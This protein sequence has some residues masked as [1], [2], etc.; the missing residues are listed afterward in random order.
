MP[1]GWEVLSRLSR[2]TSLEARRCDLPRLPA[3]LPPSLRALRVGANPQLGQGGE[4]AWNPLERLPSL[5][6][7]EA[8]FCGI[9]R[10]LPQ[11]AAATALRHL[12]LSSN[13]LLGRSDWSAWAPLARLT[14]LT[15]LEVRRCRLRAP[16]PQLAGLWSL[17]R[18]ELGCENMSGP[19]A[20]ELLG[21]L[22][23]LRWLGWLG[24]SAQWAWRSRTALALEARGVEVQ[25]MQ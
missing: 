13:Y 24:L 18:L 23:S 21:E 6:R 15:A 9:E 7:L 16:P 20:L 17:E 3:T 22:G 14:A 25:L 1:A 10:L 12:N 5:T 8:P 2:L 11:L 4:A 19:S